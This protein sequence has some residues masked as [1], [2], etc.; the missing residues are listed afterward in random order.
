MGAAVAS[1]VPIPGISQGVGGYVG[2]GVAVIIDVAPAAVDE[3]GNLAKSLLGNGPAYSE[4][5]YTRMKNACKAAGGTQV[6]GVPPDQHG[7][8]M[9][10]DGTTDGGYAPVWPAEAKATWDAA[11]ADKVIQAQNL[12][13]YIQGLKAIDGMVAQADAA[14]RKGG[15]P[16]ARNV[17][18]NKIQDAW[19]AIYHSSG[20]DKFVPL[21]PA[22]IKN[23]MYDPPQ[24]I[25]LRIYKPV[26]PVLKLPVHPP[27]VPLRIGAL[28][29][30]GA[31]GMPA[32]QKAQV[33]SV[34]AKNPQA[35]AGIKQAIAVQASQ[36]FWHKVLHFV[37]FGFVK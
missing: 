6:G 3:A 7:A 5:D 15:T 20:Q 36:S 4:D 1:L 29:A 18:M 30:S 17:W 37:T 12:T 35:V 24:G 31:S 26:M 9:F 14:M 33:A 34:L 28:V 25:D 11:Q 23:Y 13:N 16:Q 2:G 27:M 21:T 32:A 10:P 22:A 8:C 19:T